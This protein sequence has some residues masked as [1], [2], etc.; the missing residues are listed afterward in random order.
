LLNG[1]NASTALTTNNNGRLPTK[2]TGLGTTRR[3]GIVLGF[4]RSER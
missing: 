1:P 2:A 4:R 3:T